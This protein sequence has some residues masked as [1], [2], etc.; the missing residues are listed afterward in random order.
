VIP[1]VIGFGMFKAALRAF[2]KAFF[3][4]FR[5]F[6]ISSGPGASGFAAAIAAM[7]C[8]V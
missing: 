4:E 7:V 3:V 6:P 8:A 1:G 2:A 5:R